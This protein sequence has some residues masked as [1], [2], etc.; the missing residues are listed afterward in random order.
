MVDITSGCTLKSTS[1]PQVGI[2]LL[3]I[4]TAATAD[5]GDTIDVA[6]VTGVTG[7]SSVLFAI[8][9]QD[10]AGTPVCEP[11][12]VSTATL[13]IGGSTDNKTR[14]IFCVCI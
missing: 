2:K 6:T 13:T 10:Q 14:D 5:D 9:T 4:Q 11:M 3:V 12:G 1:E 8:G 7:V